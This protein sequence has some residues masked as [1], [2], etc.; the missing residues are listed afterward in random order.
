VIK[1]L[2]H[3]LSGYARH[4]FWSLLII[5]GGLF[6]YLVLALA[7]GYRPYSDRPRSG[8]QLQWELLDWGTLSFL[9]RF[10]LFLGAYLLAVLTLT[11][12]FFKFLRLIGY[13]RIVFALLGGLI[14][15]LVTFYVTLAIGWYI[16][17][18]E[19]TVIVAAGL[20]LVYGATLFPLIINQHKHPDSQEPA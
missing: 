18:N 9:F 3:F 14:T 10:L 15:G 13:N 11:F 19:L 8:L 12:I 1:E 6:I 4:L 16:A 5:L 20:G 7:V 17:I 2:K